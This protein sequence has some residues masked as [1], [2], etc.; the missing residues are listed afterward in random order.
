[1]AKFKVGDVCIILP[2]KDP[3]PE[4]KEHIG[5]ECVI[6]CVGNDGPAL[7]LKYHPDEQ[8]YGVNIPGVRGRWH[9]TEG[10]LEKKFGS[11]EEV[12]RTCKYIVPTG[13]TA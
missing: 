3:L 4:N 6:R 8:V 7:L 5:K 13:V 11:W 12:A 1:M 2:W 10:I 9:A